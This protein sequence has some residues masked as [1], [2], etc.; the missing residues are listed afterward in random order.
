ME[1]DLGK[2]GG[3]EQT[4][5][6]SKRLIQINRKV[7]FQRK[8]SLPIFDLLLRASGEFHLLPIRLASGST[9]TLSNWKGRKEVT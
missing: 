1:Y 7:R 6:H 2:T 5:E 4:N 8:R 9:K 3:I